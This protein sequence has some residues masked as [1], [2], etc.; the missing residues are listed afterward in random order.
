MKVGINMIL[1][2]IAVFIAFIV[3]ILGI[4]DLFDLIVNK[5]KIDYRLQVLYLIGYLLFTLEN[6]VRVLCSIWGGTYDKI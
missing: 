6:T 2:Y 4:K 3:V 5:K 1:D